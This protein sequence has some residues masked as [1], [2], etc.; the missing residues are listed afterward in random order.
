MGK[1]V[2]GGWWRYQSN[3]CRT[4][5]TPNVLIQASI[6]AWH[7]QGQFVRQEPRVLVRNR[8]AL[9]CRRAAGDRERMN[10]RTRPQIESRLLNLQEAAIYCGLPTRGFKKN[11]PV[12]PIRLGPHELWDK[13][14]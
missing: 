14:K 13:A 2:Q 12:K 11:V 4:I 10:A 9:S 7:H 8:R 6:R 1:P 5:P 3:V